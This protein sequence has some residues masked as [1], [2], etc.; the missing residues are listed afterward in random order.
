MFYQDESRTYENSYQPNQCNR[1]QSYDIREESQWDVCRSCGLIQPDIYHISDTDM[2][3]WVSYDDFVNDRNISYVSRPIKH[4]ETYFQDAIACISLYPKSMPLDILEDI[5]TSLQLPEHR[6]RR[7]QFYATPD[8]QT[9]QG[10]LGHVKPSAQISLDY[11]SDKT[12]KPLLKFNRKNF[13]MKWFSL[14]MYLRK[15]LR[16]QLVRGLPGDFFTILT[17]VHEYICCDFDKIRRTTPEFRQRVALPSAKVFTYMLCFIINPDIIVDYE[18]VLGLPKTETIKKNFNSIMHMMRVCYGDIQVLLKLR[19]I[20]LER[21][22]FW[23]WK[24]DQF[25]IV[26]YAFFLD[27][28]D[29][30]SKGPQK[31][32]YEKVLRLC[33]LTEEKLSTNTAN[34]TMV[35]Q[36]MILSL[37][38]DEIETNYQ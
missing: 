31:I 3:V 27:E 10:I 20:I 33:T 1:C 15:Q 19:K 2:G 29:H 21:I 14:N 24:N 18:H 22:R 11:T 38:L 26:R 37:I 28:F 13:V 30:R 8:Q 6:D 5:Y 7:L 25:Q 36:K 17:E 35:K 34:T 23:F 9:T 12:N 32:F 16:I 4:R